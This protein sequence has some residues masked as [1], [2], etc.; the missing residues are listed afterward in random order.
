MCRMK[1]SF[2]VALWAVAAV[3]SLQAPAISAESAT[4]TVN[5]YCVGRTESVGKEYQ[6]CRQLSVKMSRSKAGSFTFTYDLRDD[7]GKQIKRKSGHISIEPAELESF[8]TVC[9]QAWDLF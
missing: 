8:A 1:H 9:Y 3:L 4:Q 2:L 6:Y 5:T 7:S